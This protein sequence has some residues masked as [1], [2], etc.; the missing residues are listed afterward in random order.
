MTGIKQKP[1]WGNKAFIDPDSV[2]VSRGAVGTG[3]YARPQ[4]AMPGSQAVTAMFEDFLDTGSI[5]WTALEGDTGN[6]Q[7]ARDATGGSWRMTMGST[8][9][10]APSNYNQLSH[11]LIWK[12]NQGLDPYRSR[13]HMAARVKIGTVSRSAPD[14]CSVFVGFADTGAGQVPIYD[15]GGGL[16][17]AASNCV[18]VLYGSRADTGWSGVAANADTATSPVSLDTGV[19]SNV[20]DVVEVEVHRGLGDT[21]GTATFWINGQRQGQISSPVVT[22]RYLMPTITM[23]Q[24]DTGGGQTLDIDW[25]SVWATRDTGE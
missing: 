10:A 2:L 23:F 9:T 22:N 20:Y 11:R 1:L 24:E 12:A 8:L 7:A 25:V 21:G 15:T 13:L 17:A 5:A 3:G 19:T 14:R 6:S 4:I 16:Q 18:G